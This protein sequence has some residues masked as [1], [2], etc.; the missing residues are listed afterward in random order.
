MCD[1]VFKFWINTFVFSHN[2][3]PPDFIVLLLS[4]WTMNGKSK[5]IYSK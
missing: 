2:I 5:K 1:D 3:I 4:I